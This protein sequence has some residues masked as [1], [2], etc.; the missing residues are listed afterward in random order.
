MCHRPADP[1]SS[2][3]HPDANR[4]D[5]ELAA[6]ESA[7]QHAELQRLAS[8]EKLRALSDAA[9][10]AVILM[11][12]HGK[13]A[14]WNTSATRI[15]GHACEEAVGRAVHDLIVP[16]SFRD[17]ANRG[18][19]GF[20][21]S[22]RGSVVGRVVEFTALHK[23]GREF[24]VELSVSPILI[25]HQWCALAIVRDVSDRKQAEAELQAQRDCDWEHLRA[26]RQLLERYEAD[27]K[28]AAFDIHDSIT[29]PITSA[30]MEL[31]ALRS[32]LAEVAGNVECMGNRLTR[33][34]ALLRRCL[35]ETRRL[36]SGLRP[37]V[38]DD[39]GV[40]A[41]VESLIDDIRSQH[42]PHIEWSHALDVHRLPAD[43]ETAIYRIVQEGLANAL[44]HAESP[45]V[46]VRLEQRGASVRL[47]IQDWGKGFEPAQIPETGV[48]LIGI[49]ERA[50]IL[51]GE[52]RILSTPHAGTS[53]VVD[54]PQR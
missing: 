28:L 4:R 32:Q 6:A 1:S 18:L 13:V 49:R 37:T 53:I 48:G 10:D 25:N 26:M 41:A 3:E 40:L 27:R 24:P 2:I 11:D 38:L 7:R 44:Q 34:C 21:Q 51:G 50:R 22:G 54:L 20:A 47:E 5:A 46:R 43:M 17:D 15:F 23:N 12:A 30:L 16:H 31:D 8:E 42:G 14:H 52:A 39:F 33:G 19:P 36:M 29:Q 35:D 9:L 45:R